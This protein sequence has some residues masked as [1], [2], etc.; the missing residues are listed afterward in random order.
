MEGG[1]EGVEDTLLEISGQAESGESEPGW[2]R[3]GELKA[4][5]IG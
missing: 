1:V 4:K 5:S 2:V 3:W